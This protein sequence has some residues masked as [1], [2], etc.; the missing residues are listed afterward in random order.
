MHEASL[1]TGLL[2]Q[3]KAIAKEEGAKKVTGVKVWCG[4][5]SHMTKAHFAEH[6]ELAA[7]GTLAEHAMLDVTISDDPADDRAQDVVLESID[8]AD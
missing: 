1:M 8:V 2:S 4:A 7:K 6:F 5:L 3:I